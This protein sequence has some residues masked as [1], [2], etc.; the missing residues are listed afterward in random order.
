MMEMDDNKLKEL[1]QEEMMQEADRI[2]EEVNKDPSMKDVV[3][4]EEIYERLKQQIREHEETIEHKEEIS[5]ENE[6]LI[7]LGKIYKKNRSRRK[8][9]VLVA[10]VVCLLAFGI[11]SI[12]GA[13]KVFTEMKR[14]LGDKEQT[15][16]NTQEK[17]GRLIDEIAS[18]EDA[19]RII[20]DDM[21]IYPVKMFYLP[22]GIEFE[23]AIIEEGI[24]SA[25]LYYT[26]NEG[27]KIYYYIFT[28]HR[29][30]SIGIDVEDKILQEYEKELEEVVIKV[31]EY[32][33]SESDERRWIASFV[34]KNS[35]YSIMMMGI[36]ENEVNKI[37]ENL[38]FS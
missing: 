18:E 4:P 32:L 13:K 5:A 37:I 6:E 11:T 2:M 35:Q 17:E 3:A 36:G 26:D 27:R 20:D 24:Q 38:Y 33:V 1:L 23:E 21:D 22:E 7:R 31:Q 8:Y 34:Y 29:S 12:G 9:F 15:V 14:M 19:Y 16:M 28:N 30:G 10:A 25:R